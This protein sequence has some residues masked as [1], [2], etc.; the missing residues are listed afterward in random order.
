[1]IDEEKKALIESYL[2][3]YNRLDVDAMVALVH[4]Q[5]V[6]QNI[7]GGQVNAEAIGADRFR[8]LAVRSKALFSSRS[9]KVTRCDIDGKEAVAEIAY[10]AVLA[11]DLPNGPKALERLTL[12]G[13]SRFAFKDGK[14]Y[15]IT[16]IS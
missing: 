12:N 9:Q 5:V 1:M 2:A 6:F 13:Q 10:E 3:A 7:S 11:V 8:E 16:D 14:I 4:P 15:K